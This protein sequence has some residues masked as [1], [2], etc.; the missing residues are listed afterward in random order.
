MG[1][2]S[3]L[4]LHIVRQIVEKH[5]GSIEVSSQPGRTIFTVMIPI[6]EE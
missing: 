3:G 2:G 5:Q 6:S 4:G 1:E